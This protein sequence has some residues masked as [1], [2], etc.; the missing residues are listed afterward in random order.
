MFSLKGMAEQKKVFCSLN[1]VIDRTHWVYGFPQIV[2][3][4]MEA[5][6]TKPYSELGQKG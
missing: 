3:E 4:F 2:H 1:T 6:F 5:Q